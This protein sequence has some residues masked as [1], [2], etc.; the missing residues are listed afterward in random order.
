MTIESLKKENQRL[1]SKLEENENNNSRKE[2]LSEEIE[3]TSPD[4]AD[5]TDI[6]K[7]ENIPANIIVEDNILTTLALKSNDNE[8]PSIPEP[9]KKLEKRF[10]ETMEKVAELT[11]EKQRLEHL[12]LQLQGETETIGKFLCFNLD[13]S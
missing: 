4:N 13:L 9:F 7:R 6:R 3:Q 8:I 2:K 5:E 1:Q 12:V 11:D 10:K